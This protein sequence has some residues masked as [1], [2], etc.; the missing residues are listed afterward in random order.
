MRTYSYIEDF[1]STQRDTLNLF[2]NTPSLSFDLNKE[3]KSYDTYDYYKE[4]GNIYADNTNFGEKVKKEIRFINYIHK[5]KLIG[6]ETV[7]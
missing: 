3:E 4:I 2:R 5:M 1:N 7:Q 6:E